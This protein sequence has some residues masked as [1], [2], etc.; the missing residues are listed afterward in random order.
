MR[1]LCSDGPARAIQCACAIN[2]AVRELGI[3]V[4]AGL[5]TGEVERQPGGNYAG[6]AVHIGARV[7]ALAG[8]GEVLVTSTVPMLVHG[9]GLKFVDRGTREL[10]GVA[11]PWQ[12]F[13]VVRDPA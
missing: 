6:V 4:R 2:D 8:A 11:E 13:A 3:E 12:L 1:V 7:A 10:K 9:S 5:H